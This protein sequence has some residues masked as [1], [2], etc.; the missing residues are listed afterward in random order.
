[1]GNA[2]LWF[3]SAWDAQLTCAQVNQVAEEAEYVASGP[4]SNKTY[5]AFWNI[6]V[7]V[8]EDLMRDH[9]DYC[10]G[11]SSFYAF[12]CQGGR[13]RRPSPLNLLTRLLLMELRRCT[14]HEWV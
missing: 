2:L 8:T 3:A 7:F 1:M 9:W 12:L 5:F 14:V 4:P 6:T 13:V 11:I 10:Q